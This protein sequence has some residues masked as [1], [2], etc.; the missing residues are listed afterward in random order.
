MSSMADN[1]LPNPILMCRQTAE[2]VG[3]GLTL[4]ERVSQPIRSRSGQEQLFGINMD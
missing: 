1:G 3:Q 2:P 4:S